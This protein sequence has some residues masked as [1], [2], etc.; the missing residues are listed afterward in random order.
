MHPF[1]IRWRTAERVLPV[2]PLV[3]QEAARV[4]AFYPGLKIWRVDIE[5][6]PSSALAP[7]SVCVTVEARA[8]ERQVIVS[9]DHADAAIAVRGV[10]DTLLRRYE[11]RQGVDRRRGEAREKTQLRAA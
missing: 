10:F 2:E 8:S 4:H 6:I 9:R 11:R 1:P 5:S 7:A 3:R